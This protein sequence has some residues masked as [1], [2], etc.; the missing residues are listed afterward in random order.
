MIKTQTQVKFFDY[1]LQFRIHEE[2]YKRVIMDVLSRGAFI[3]G[4]E[5]K[6]FEENLAKFVGTKFAIG[7]GNCTD[8]LLVSLSAAGI[9]PG[10]EVITVSHT[11]V[12]TVEVIKFLGGTPVFVDIGEDHQMNVDLVEKAITSKTK[13]IMP[14]QLNGHICFKM[15]KLVEL[16]NNHGLII[17][18]DSAQALG[19]TYQGKGA[20]SFGLS[21]N[22]SFYPAKLLGTFGDAGAVVTNDP[23]FADKIWKLRNHG[24]GHGTDIEMWGLNL[25]MDNLHAAILNYKLKF[26]PDWIKRRR[27]IAA[28]YHQGLSS[29]QE[30][31]LPP[32]PNDDPDHYDVFQNYELESDRRDELIKYLK[33]HGIDAVIQWGGKAVHQFPAL[34]LSHHKLPRTEKLFKRSFMLPLYPELEN[35]QI[36]HVVDTVRSFYHA[37]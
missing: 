1:P 28:L 36:E 15:D 9:K 29:I 13:A 25:R 21:G 19:A 30:L 34:G 6:S 31:T 26:L 14:V 24:R 20:G 10:D 8:A 37:R 4:A 2:E 23:E 5:L 27:E 18:E 16:A 12:A 32:G 11:F 33:E 35:L 17:I 7:V 22:F 3:L